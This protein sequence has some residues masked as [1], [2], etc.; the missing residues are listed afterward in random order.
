MGG[1]GEPTASASAPTAAPIAAPA[2]APTAPSA[3]Q[4]APFTPPQST[5]FMSMMG[6]QGPQHVGRPGPNLNM[7]PPQTA[8]RDFGFKGIKAAAPLGAGQPGIAGILSQLQG[9][10]PGAAPDASAPAAPVPAFDYAKFMAQYGGGTPHAAPADPAPAAPTPAVDFSQLMAQY[11]GGVQHAAPTPAA[12]VPAPA[13][14]A[15]TY[16]DYMSRMRGF[17][18]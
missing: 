17:H 5:G 8:G 1:G 2:A 16:A 7:L 9:A 18:L 6:D 11:G 13:A 14:P 15:P 12:P 4:G 3:P 10:Q